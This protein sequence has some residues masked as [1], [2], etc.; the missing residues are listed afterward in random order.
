[1]TS[2][3][4]LDFGGNLA[5]VTLWFASQL[6]LDRGYRFPPSSST[7]HQLI[8]CGLPEDLHKCGY[9]QLTKTSLTTF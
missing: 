1:M 3:N 7:N 4:S 5:R 9:D 8:G 2:K 6:L